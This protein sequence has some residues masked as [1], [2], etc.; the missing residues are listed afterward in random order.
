MLSNI[1]SL[2]PLRIVDVGQVKKNKQRGFSKP[3]KFFVNI[4]VRFVEFIAYGIFLLE[5]IFGSDL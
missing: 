5:Q 1:M 4:E 2:L 3:V